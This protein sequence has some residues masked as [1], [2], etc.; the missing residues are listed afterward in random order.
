MAIGDADEAVLAAKFAVMRQVL[1]ERQWRVYLGAEANALGYGGTAAVARAAGASE[2]TV[3]AGAAEALDPDALT[4]LAP[5]RSRRPGAGRPRAEDRRPGLT[6]VLKDLLEDGKRG[7]PMS[8]MTWSTL[9]LRDIAR[10]MVLLGFPVSKDTVA[11]LMRA[12]GWSLQGMSRVLEGSQHEDRDDQF[13]HING[14]IAACQAAGDPVIST[15]AKKKE[16]LGAYFR[17]GR[18]WRPAKDPVKVRDHD[19]RDK[20]TVRIVPYGIYDITANRGFVSVGTSHDTA[21][22]AVSAIRL[23]WR[24]E[25]QFRYPAAGRL[26]ITCDA[27]GS[28]G[29]Q[30]RLWKD[31]LAVLAEETGLRIGVCHFPPGT[32]KWN[33]VEHRLFCHI[34]RTWKA[35]PLM[36]IDD[37]VAGIA[38]TITAQGLKCHPVRDDGDY[39]D[40]IKISDARMSYLEDRVLERDAFHGEWN[41]AVL[42]RPRP[43]PE[44]E[45][46]PEPARPGRVPAAVLNHP[47]LTGIPATDLTALAAALDVRFEAR[48]QQRNYTLRGGPR[49][50]AVRSSR[51]HGNRRLGVTDHLLALRLRDHLGLP[52]QVIGVLLGIDGGTVS[53][54]TALAAGLLAAARITVP[55]A[56]PPENPPRSPAA[57]LEYAAAAGIPL[58]IPENR[59]TMPDHFRTRKKRAIRDTPETGN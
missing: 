55:A 43:A 29:W 11:R 25:G 53:H 21:A 49:I 27:G 44:P 4:A 35:R 51:T 47:A 30:C 16:H 24:E 32:S 10:Q 34:T 42:P 8:E 39:P 48:L 36:T 41:Y 3:A 12:G 37:A 7:D 17:D 46:E 2:N 6:R 28:N 57:L 58:T 20:D 9:S 14:Q 18:S 31:R 38:A 23:W 33:K 5:G 15:D 45:P 54:A 1:D 19:F 50:T 56:P 59:Q 26:L 22:F 13:R 40:G 52:V